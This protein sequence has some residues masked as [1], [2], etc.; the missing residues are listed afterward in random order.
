MFHTVCE[1]LRKL[2]EG[3]IQN[4]AFTT[5]FQGFGVGFIK[6]MSTTLIRLLVTDLGNHS[7]LIKL[8]NKFV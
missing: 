3:E 4:P 7:Y 6:C 5:T 1:E 2:I 8:T